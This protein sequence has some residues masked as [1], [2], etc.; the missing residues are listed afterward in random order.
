MEYRL[1]RHDGEYRWVLDTGVPRLHTD[2][3]F[4]GYIGSA[5]DITE[6]KL[7]E[8]ALSDISGKLIEAEERERTRI[9]REL[10]D[11]INQQLALVAIELDQ[12]KQN[13]P[14]S[15]AQ[16]RSRVEAVGN[17]TIEISSGIQALSQHQVEV[18]FS[19]ADVPDSLPRNISLCLFRVL[20]G[21]LTNAVKHSGVKR[22]VARL[23]GTSGGIHLTVRD[24]GAGFELEQVLSGRGIGFV[25]M[26]ERVRLVNGRI[27]IQ[28]KL[29]GGTTIEVEVPLS[30][31]GMNSQSSSNITGFPNPAA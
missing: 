1:R 25:S 14:K 20:Q 10:H 19:H 11:D 6:R 23:G 22:F 7:A 9:A 3:F 13:P 24:E 8:E 29:K 4:A 15:L 21:A 16:L 12:L 28:S 5:I 31:S 18:N 30:T 26:R 2:G 27:S 17:R